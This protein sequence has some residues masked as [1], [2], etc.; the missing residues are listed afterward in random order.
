MKR[1]HSCLPR[2]TLILVAFLFAFASAAGA[3]EDPAAD[4]KKE[5]QAGAAFFAHFRQRFGLSDNERYRSMA[6]E[7]LYRLSRASGER[8]ELEWHSAVLKFHPANPVG[9]NASA[10][11]GGYVLT[12]DAFMDLMWEAS[13]KDERRMEGMVAGVMAHEVGH[14]MN[15]DTDALVRLYFQQAEASPARIANTLTSRPATLLVRAA[16]QRRREDEAD[17]AGAFY[18]L[19]AGY[20]IKEMIGVFEHMA[21]EEIGEVLFTSELDHA[22]SADRVANLLRVQAEVAEDQTR[23]D[24]AVLLLKLDAG[25]AE[26]AGAIADLERVRR[27]FPNSTAVRHAQAVA[28]HRKYLASVAPTD[29]RFRPAFAFYRFRALRA[30][31]PPEP[32]VQSLQQAADLYQEILRRGEKTEY[33][34]LDPTVGAYALALAQLGRLDP[35]LRWARRATSLAPDVWQHWNTLGNVLQARG[36]AAGAADAY[37]RALSLASARYRLDQILKAVH[38]GGGSAGAIA[39]GRIALMEVG[40]AIFGLACAQQEA[41][42]TGPA[43]GLLRLYLAF[44]GES[45]WSQV[46]AARLRALGGPPLPL[47]VTELAGVRVG[48]DRKTVEETLGPPEAQGK[49]EEGARILKYLKRGVRVVLE[50]Q[51]HVS[52]LIAMSPFSGEVGA[53]GVALGAPAADLASA[54]GNPIIR[55]EVS[56]DVAVWDYPPSGLTLVVGRKGL[57]QA[58]VY[59][60]PE[61]AAPPAPAAVIPELP[62][63]FAVQPGDTREQVEKALGAPSQVSGD[64]VWVYPERGLR[65]RFGAEG[66]AARVVVTHPS[67]EAVAGIHL[68]DPASKIQE[69]LGETPASLNFDDTVTYTA[70][71]RGLAFIARDGR[72]V[73]MTLFQL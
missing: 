58:I 36:D 8:P 48:A 10:W 57:E 31:T 25:G 69:V 11:P 2:A 51:E 42:N 50:D 33:A 16:E 5:R 63:A 70:P 49:S 26:L 67:A 9:R 60:R 66:R 44:D 15:R 24:E 47:R 43:I 64:G 13:G 29:Q 73:T 54:F 7:V 30:E 34:G 23:F 27:H 28:C 55:Q 68:A 61:D 14:V 40:P 45:E 39:A 53:A 20:S 3:A 19:R 72:V 35:A 17:R 62:R 22:R 18:L 52:A 37:A 12:D 38:G 32:D 65:V 21:R 71:G 46:A 1:E 4:L 59:G 56:P 41:G 6:N